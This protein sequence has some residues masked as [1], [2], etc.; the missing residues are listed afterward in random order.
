MARAPTDRLWPVPTIPDQSQGKLSA[1]SDLDLAV[2]DEQPASAAHKTTELMRQRRF[3]RW[4]RTRMWSFFIFFI[5]QLHRN[6]QAQCVKLD[7]AGGF[8]VV[9]GLTCGVGSVCIVPILAPSACGSRNFKRLSVGFERLARKP[10]V[11]SGSAS[12]LTMIGPF[13]LA[14]GFLCENL[15]A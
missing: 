12:A 6:F 7:K 4:Y 14:S 2:G 15:I 10:F 8:V 11:I 5:L 3:C 1:A 9:V 13:A